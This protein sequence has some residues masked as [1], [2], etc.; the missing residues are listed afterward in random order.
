[1]QLD[2]N[3]VAWAAGLYEGEGSVFHSKPSNAF[4]LTVQMT[5]VDVVKRFAQIFDTH[6]YGPHR[7]SGR[8]GRKSR[9]DA[10]TGALGRVQTII[11]AMWPYLGTRRRAQAKRVL[12]E[13]V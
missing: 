9:Y 7:I 4:V 8:G 11:G 5:D 10:R 2:S 1:M 12:Q 6:I 3:S 13:A